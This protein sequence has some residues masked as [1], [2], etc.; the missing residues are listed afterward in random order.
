[1]N[2]L[3]KK[4]PCHARGCLD[5]TMKMHGVTVRSWRD[6]DAK[7]EEWELTK[8]VS[9]NSRVRVHTFQHPDYAPREVEVTPR[10]PNSRWYKQWD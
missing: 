10:S 1:M 9:K 4:Y 7:L 8:S 2:S 5:L 6:Q 3:Y